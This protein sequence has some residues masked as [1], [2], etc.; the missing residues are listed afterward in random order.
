[1]NDHF[2]PFARPV[3]KPVNDE[4]LAIMSRQHSA[5]VQLSIAISIIAG[6]TL[7]GSL[8]LMV[9]RAPEIAHAL[10]VERPA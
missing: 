8:A 6:L 10:A 2:T 7:G 4:L 1:M 5:L 9:K 3:G